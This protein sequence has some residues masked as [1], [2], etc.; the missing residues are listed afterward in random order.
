MITEDPQ[1]ALLGRGLLGRLLGTGIVEL[2]AIAVGGERDQELVDVRAG[3]AD[4]LE[5]VLGA[6]LFQQLRERGLVELRELVR[7]IVRDRERRRVEVAAIEPDDGHLIEPELE[8]R[9]QAR[10]AGDDLAAALGHDRLL[11]TEPLDGRR[12]VRHAGLIDARVGRAQEQ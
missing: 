9:L 7:P 6:Q 1:V 2:A 11:P 10:V 8:R 12:D 5:A 4:A 3:V